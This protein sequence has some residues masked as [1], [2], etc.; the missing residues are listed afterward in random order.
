MLDLL[1][2]KSSH[3]CKLFKLLTQ[4]NTLL[5]AQLQINMGRNLIEVQQTVNEKIAPKQFSESLKKRSV[6]L[7]WANHIFTFAITSRANGPGVRSCRSKPHVNPEI[8]LV[9]CQKLKTFQKKQK[10]SRKCYNIRATRENSGCYDWQKNVQ[11]TF[12]RYCPSKILFD[13]FI[14]YQQCITVLRPVWRIVM[15]QN[16]LF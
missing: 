7:I 12:S 2:R 5:R 6:N 4:M 1:L 3:L 9:K 15:I 13:V 14:F 8:A 10:N 16:S 11:I